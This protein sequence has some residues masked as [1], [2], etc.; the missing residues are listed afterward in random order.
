M[1]S[2]P[3]GGLF[4][5]WQ[6]YNTWWDEL[7]CRHPL[8]A[9]APCHHWALA[10]GLGRMYLLL[11]LC[12]L[13]FSDTPAPDKLL[14][15]ITRGLGWLEPEP[16]PFPLFPNFPF[17]CHDFWTHRPLIK[18]CMVVAWFSIITRGSEWVSRGSKNTTF[19][20]WP[21]PLQHGGHWAILQCYN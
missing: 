5:Q 17:A 19:S 20:S 7:A 3:A 14:P 13:W 16:A 2:C 10:R 12:W 21:F 15:I 11:S 9:M 1:F 4:E 6:C 8:V 18:T